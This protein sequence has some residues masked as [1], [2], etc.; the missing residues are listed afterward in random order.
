VIDDVYKHCVLLTDENRQKH[1]RIYTVTLYYFIPLTIILICY[2]KLL[3]YVY[4]K[5]N[6]LKPKTVGEK[7][8]L[9]ISIC[10]FLVEI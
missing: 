3:Y 8:N 2:T 6:K 1:F 10:V 7:A 5:E 4:S 9:F